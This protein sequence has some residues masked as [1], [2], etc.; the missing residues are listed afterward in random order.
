MIFIKLCEGR[1]IATNDLWYDSTMS[2][3]DD[4]GWSRSVPSGTLV[5]CPSKQGCAAPSLSRHLN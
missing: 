1:I 4:D 2:S 5:G 3:G